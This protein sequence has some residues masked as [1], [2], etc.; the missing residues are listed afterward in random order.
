MFRKRKRVLSKR[1]KPMYK[2]KA[3]RSFGLMRTGG[4][5]AQSYNGK[6]SPE[7]K[8]KD[9]VP[10]KNSMVFNS[11]S[12]NGTLLCN[13]LAQ[14][15]EYNTRIGR[16]ILMKSLLIRATIKNTADLANKTL[17]GN[18]R[19]LVV[20][21]KQV[22][23]VA[24]ALTDIIE[25]TSDSTFAMTSPLNLNNRDRFIVLSD[26]IGS[27]TVTTAATQGAAGDVA[28][29]FVCKNIKIYKK[30]NHETIYN[31][32][33]AGTV[34]DINTGALYVFL[35]GDRAS[36]TE[37]IICQSIITRLRFLDA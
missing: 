36:G 37:N 7:L 35:V 30:L 19:L 18:Y 6:P 5:F 22:N 13:G 21:D 14:G 33:V 29:F 25:T 17:T 23:A 3:R 16:K 15:S 24:P 1:K 10:T 34:G 31:S 20:Y 2:R 26:K 9:N 32:G 11:S 27:L 12:T 28:A 4:N 8:V